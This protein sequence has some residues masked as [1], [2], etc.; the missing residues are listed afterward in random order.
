MKNRSTIILFVV[1]VF[2]L[3]FV[4]YFGLQWYNQRFHKLPVYSELK[5]AGAMQPG[6]PDDF[7]LVNQDGDVVSLGDWNDKII[8][9][10][11]FFTRCPSICPKM[12]SSL[13]RVRKRFRNDSTIY[14]YS[15]S[16]DPE[17]DSVA[18]LRKYAERFKM[19]LRYWQL[20]TGDKKEIYRIARN[21]FKVA[22]TDGDG[23]PG[24]FIHSEKL[25][26]VDRHQRIR[27][28]YKGTV[29][30]EVDQL[31]KDIK[32]LKNEKE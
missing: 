21:N 13:Q 20:L 6:V 8:V 5:K 1:L 3:P 19:D 26:L 14:M 25:I 18:Q 12:T 27:G 7:E 11:F 32:K 10:D 22:A 2:V 4:A 17:N 16:V 23:G 28:Y 9:V 24:D 31:I 30:E 29:D 15:I